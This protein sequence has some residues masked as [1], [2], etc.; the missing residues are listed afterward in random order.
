MDAADAEL[1][2]IEM[3]FQMIKMLREKWSEVLD[4]LHQFRVALVEIDVRW[5]Q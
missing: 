2:A 1:L 3:M 5:S 4:L